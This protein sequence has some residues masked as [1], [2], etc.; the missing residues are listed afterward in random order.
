MSEEVLRQYVLLFSFSAVNTEDELAKGCRLH[1]AP[2]KFLRLFLYSS[3]VA[4]TVCGV[5]VCE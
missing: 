4:V 5:C 1:E 2:V 3:F